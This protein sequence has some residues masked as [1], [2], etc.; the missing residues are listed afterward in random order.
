MKKI[1]IFSIR[2]KST[3]AYRDKNCPI[4]YARPNRT[5]ARNLVKIGRVVFERE[6][7]VRA[8]FVS[9]FDHVSLPKKCLLLSAFLVH[10]ERISKTET[11]VLYA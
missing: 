5:P 10:Y 2:T 7:V 11:R 8:I 9:V 1:A 4:F 6:S 3:V